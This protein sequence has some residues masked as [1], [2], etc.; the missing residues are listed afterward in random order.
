[1]DRRSVLATLGAGVVASL[2]GCSGIG[3]REQR[4]ETAIPITNREVPATVDTDRPRA[5]FQGSATHTGHYDTAAPGTELTTYWRRTPD[6]GGH[7]QPVVVGERL[8]ISFAGTLLQLDRSTG[9]VQ[10]RTNVGF[11]GTATPAV[12]DESAYVTVWN[13]GDG[14]ERGLA[15]VDAGTGDVEWRARTEANVTT[16]VTTTEDGVFV[17]GGFETSTVAAFDHA[18]TRQWHHE[19]GEYASTPAVADGTA[20][21]GAGTDAVVAFDAVTGDEQWRYRT[22]GE[23]TATPTI[24]DDLVVV[25][26]RGGTLYALDLADGTPVWT[27]SLPRMRESVAATADRVVAAA[28]EEVVA[29]DSSGTRVWTYEDVGQPTAPVV[30]DG[31]VVFGDWKRLRGLSLDDGDESW[32]FETRSRQ[33]GDV[34]LQGIRAAPTVSDGIVFTGTQAGDV[35]ALES[36]P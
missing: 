22:D 34:T 3:G 35:Y 19:L 13:G 25:G 28:D 4:R 10:W 27:A 14:W 33:A 36:D 16:T 9:Q 23:T 31:T 7:S 29:I 8:C 5:Q 20:V 2:S 24:V 15:A 17:G 32:S 30:A 21:Y 6:R 11:D 18:G 26:T 1:M 12:H